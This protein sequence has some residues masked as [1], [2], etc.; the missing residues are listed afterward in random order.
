MVNP[1][2]EIYNS[3]VGSGIPAFQGVRIQRGH[4]FF[5]NLFSGIGNLIKNWAP[6][7]LKS[8]LPSGVGLA[9]DIISGENV[10][11][12][13]LNRLK[14]AGKA[15]GQHTIDRVASHFQHGKGRKRKRKTKSNKRKRKRT[16][17]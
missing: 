14:E 1:Y 10:K 2:I 12:S 9:Q 4:G 13:T 6:G 17:R 8:I 11:Q 7:V 3:Q 16:K 5:G 15:A